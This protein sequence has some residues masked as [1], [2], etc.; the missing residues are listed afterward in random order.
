MKI[1]RSE[2]KEIIREVLEEAVSNEKVD[3]REVAAKM[4]ANKD[5]FGPKFVAAVAKRGKV[6]HAD[7]EE[8]LPDF[9]PGRV[10]ASLF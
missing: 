8:M 3:A 1:K 4:K 6:S 5:W 7:L 9:I 10:I 2:L